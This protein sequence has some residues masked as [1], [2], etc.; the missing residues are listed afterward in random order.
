MTKKH[1]LKQRTT[2]PIFKELAELETNP[3][4]RNYLTDMSNGFFRNKLIFRDDRVFYYKFYKAIP[5]V[6]SFKNKVASVE[7]L[8]RFINFLRFRILIVPDN[9]LNVKKADCFHPSVFIMKTREKIQEL[10]THNYVKTLPLEKQQETSDTI[11]FGFLENRWQECNFKF[12]GN[13]II[14]F[15]P[16]AEIKKKTRKKKTHT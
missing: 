10:L 6:F 8:E 11:F 2:S 1:H 14:D 7:L 12:K 16:D 5:A 13:K 3:Y 4:W 15:I 9:E